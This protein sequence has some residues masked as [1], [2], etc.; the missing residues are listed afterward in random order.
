MSLR[1]PV[2]EGPI[3]CELAQRGKSLFNDTCARCHGTYGSEGQ[4]PSRHVP[5]EEVGTDRVRLDALPVEGRQ[6]YANSWFAH[7]G[8]A[9][10]QETV[11]DP[12]GYL[13]PPLFLSD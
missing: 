3:D 7:A 6:K 2:Y 1:A 10:P 8:E 5:W 9:D 13:A 4:Y 12:D 11:V